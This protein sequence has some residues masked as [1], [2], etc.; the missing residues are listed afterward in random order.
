MDTIIIFDEAHKSDK[1]RLKKVE[2]AL[3][4]LINKA[5]FDDTVAGKNY[6]LG[7]GQYNKCNGSTYR[8]HAQ[9]YALALIYFTIASNK[10]F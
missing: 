8:C 5:H 1:I 10:L 9:D 4:M 7:L 2:K 3:E 6:T